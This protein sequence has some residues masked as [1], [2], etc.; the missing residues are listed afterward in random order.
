MQV[1]R[2]TPLSLHVLSLPPLRRLSLTSHPHLTPHRPR[3]AAPTP[4]WEYVAPD[5]STQGPYPASRMVKWLDADY[6]PDDLQLRELG[7]PAWT[8]LDA[9]KGRLRRQAAGPSAGGGG[10]GGAPAQPR[11]PRGGGGG[12]G[13]GKPD[14]NSNNPKL[15]TG[16]KPAYGKDVAR[17]LF[18]GGAR[19]ATDEPVWRYRDPAGVVQG[20]FPARSMLDWYARGYLA[21]RLPVAGCDRKVAPP[22]VPPPSLYRPLGDLLAA[23]AA[24]TPP[25]ALTLED[26]KSA[27][28]GGGG[29]GGKKGKDKA[30]AGAGAAAGA[31]AATAGAAAGA[32]A[33]AGKGKGKG[34]AGDR[35]RDAAGGRGGRG[36]RDRD[37]GARGRGRDAPD[38]PARPHV[39]VTHMIKCVFARV[40]GL[41]EPEAPPPRLPRA[42]RERKGRKGGGGRAAGGGVGDEAAASAATEG[43]AGLKLD[44]GDKAADKAADAGA[45]AGASAAPAA[46][47]DAKP[48]AAGDASETPTSPARGLLGAAAGFFGFGGKK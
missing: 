34:R 40:Q 4:E 41:P 9:V 29:G 38:R 46:A 12:R 25:P 42:P 23:A 43:V 1:T 6:F 22:H 28:A 15:T 44:G 24:G 19:L 48:A 36:E 18:T 45:A 47:A 2:N 21:P 14:G 17:L 32:A 16:A 31:A 5:G 26:V 8:T 33:P 27:P 37:A 39:L 7:R 30:S 10:G 11:S 3:Q 35:D 13:G 20:P